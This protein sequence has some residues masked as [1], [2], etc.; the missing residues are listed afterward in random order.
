MTAS[1]DVAAVK[2][3]MNLSSSSSEAVALVELDDRSR[4]L[5]DESDAD[6]KLTDFSG[7]AP[8][9]LVAM[10]MSMVSMLLR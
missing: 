6:R 1:G 10:L 9:M 5:H 3:A 2:D 7:F 4:S 8:A